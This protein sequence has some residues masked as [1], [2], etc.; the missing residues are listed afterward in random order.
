MYTL[1]L[2][3]FSLT[4]GSYSVTTHSDEGPGMCPHGGRYLGAYSSDHRCTI[5]PNGGCVGDFANTDG[6]SILDPIG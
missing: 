2:L 5:D 3:L 1:I 6:R 4:F